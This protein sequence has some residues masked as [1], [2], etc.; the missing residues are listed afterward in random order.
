MELLLNLND[1]IIN[2]I[3]NDQEE[4]LQPLQRKQ[5]DNLKDNIRNK[6]Q[7]RMHKVRFTMESLVIFYYFNSFLIISFVLML[8]Q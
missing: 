5:E 8:K 3:T 7:S 4:N 6:L 1:K 2:Q